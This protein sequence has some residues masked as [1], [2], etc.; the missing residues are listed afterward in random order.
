MVA[1][2]WVTAGPVSTDPVVQPPA[3]TGFTAAPSSSAPENTVLLSWDAVPGAGSRLHYRIEMST[4]ELNL[5]VQRVDR[6]TETTYEH[7]VD[8]PDIGWEYRVWTVN[9]YG[10]GVVLSEV[11]EATVMPNRPPTPTGVTASPRGTSA[12]HINWGYSPKE[13]GSIPRYELQFRSGDVEGAEWERVPSDYY[14]YSPRY[15]HSGRPAGSTW[16]YRARAVRV[17]LYGTHLVVSDWSETV[18]ATTD[19]DIGGL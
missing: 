14:P 19:A 7:V 3:P 10:A 15:T 13:A 8:R 18:T 9:D 6:H 12:V 17:G 11:A 1:G 16:E 5:P 4:P 2:P